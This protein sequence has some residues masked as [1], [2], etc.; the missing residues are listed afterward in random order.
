MQLM[1]KKY[2]P[3]ALMVALMVAFICPLFLDANKAFALPSLA[4]KQAAGKKGKMTTED[5]VVE[6]Q[7]NKGTIK[8]KL[9]QKEMPI[10]VANFISLANSNFY[11]GL[12]FHRYE[13][14]FCV[15]GGDPTGTGS[16][17]SGKT[18]PLEVDG[19]KVNQFPR[20]KFSK[21]GVL[22]MARTNV[23]D[24]ATSQFFF[25]LGPA[26][27][28]DGKY[29]A[30]G[31]VIDGMDVVMALRKDDKMTKVSVLEGAKK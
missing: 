10:T 31:E 7:T 23:P 19:Q 5:P 21:A 20:L 4:P 2:G 18:I 9:F 11:N 1:L 27:F 3:A 13:P 17:G 25:T 8:A 16:G 24:S 28:L 22:G 15:Q 26:S 14:N 29:A 12:V 6:I 30:F